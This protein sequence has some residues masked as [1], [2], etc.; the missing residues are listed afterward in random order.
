MVRFDRVSIVSEVTSEE[1]AR[2]NTKA[3]R[4]YWSASVTMMKLSV[5]HLEMMYVKAT[6][7][8]VMVSQLYMD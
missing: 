2:I 6:I 7:F 8:L 5:T 1:S 4:A 3:P